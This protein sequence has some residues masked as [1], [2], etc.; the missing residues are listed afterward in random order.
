[1]CAVATVLGAGV[2]SGWSAAGQTPGMFGR[3]GAVHDVSATGGKPLS[4]TTVG[5]RCDG[6][7]SLIGVAYPGPR[8]PVI[9]GR[10]QAIPRS[11]PRRRVRRPRKG[12]VRDSAQTA[13]D[14]DRGRRRAGR[15]VGWH[16]VQGAQRPRPAAAGDARAGARGRQAARL[17]PQRAGAR[18]ARGTQLHG[19]IDHYRQL[20]PVHHPDHARC[21]GRARGR[22]DLGVHVRR[23][24]R[25]HPRTALHPHPAG[26]PRRRHRHHRAAGRSAS[27]HRAPTCRSRS[28]TR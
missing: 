10:T 13:P 4:A 7:Q 19:R 21:R 28:S 8:P 1:M 25:R 2:G 5:R 14:D 11:V 27:T 20:R 18:P 24:R 12:T 26:A 17:L 23:P 16:R 9:L 15:G 3:R 22:P 6:C